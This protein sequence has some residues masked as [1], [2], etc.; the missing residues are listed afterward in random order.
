MASWC[1]PWVQGHIFYLYLCGGSI[2]NS[3]QWLVCN[4]YIL[5]PPLIN[6]FVYLNIGF[7]S[8]HLIV[9]CRNHICN[10]TYFPQYQHSFHA[11]EHRKKHI[12][13]SP[14][15][16]FLNRWCTLLYLILLMP[17][18]YWSAAFLDCF[19]KFE[20]YCDSCPCIEFLF[21]AWFCFFCLIFLDFS[22]SSF[23]FPW[24]LFL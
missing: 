18:Y 9:F 5:L 10:I 17:P 12:V 23:H 22:T 3:Y 13:S 11:P 16:K 4:N 7:L 14:R 15:W 6:Y 21:L 24:S 20:F 2:I 1:C 19:L 8:P